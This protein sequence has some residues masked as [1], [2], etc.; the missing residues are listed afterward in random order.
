MSNHLTAGQRALLRAA[1]EQRQH[2]LDRRLADHLGGRSRAEHAR[3]VLTQD[4]D[5]APQRESER[6]MDMALTDLETQ[7]VGEVSEALRRIDSDGYGQCTDCGVEIPFDRLRAEPW[8]LRCVPCE[9]RR[10]QKA[11]RRRG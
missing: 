6:E 10:E 3:E 7:E 4:D 8:A 11:Q 2:Q 9:S 5:D 1:L